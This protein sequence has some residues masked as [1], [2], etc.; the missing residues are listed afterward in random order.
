M[1]FFRDKLGK[2]KDTGQVMSTKYIKSALIDECLESMKDNISSLQLQSYRASLAKEI[3]FALK[4]VQFVDVFGE[5]AL[6]YGP[7]LNRKILETVVDWNEFMD[8][9]KEEIVRWL[10]KDSIASTISSNEEANRFLLQK[11]R[12]E[13]E[14]K[15]YPASMFDMMMVPQLSLFADADAKTIQG[16]SI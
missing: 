1:E 11:T 12:L 10:S 9:V 7:Q 14:A 16:P 6:L 2:R 5:C 4:L 3:S 13:L 15:G 8:A